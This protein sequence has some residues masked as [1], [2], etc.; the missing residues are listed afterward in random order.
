LKNA[1]YALDTF[2]DLGQANAPTMQATG[3]QRRDRFAKVIRI[4][5]GARHFATLQ[6]V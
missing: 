5:L 2:D 6:R 4:N 1:E 3:Y